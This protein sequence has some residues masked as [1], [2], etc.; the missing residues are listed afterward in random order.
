MERDGSGSFD[1]SIIEYSS[2]LLCPLQLNVEQSGLA[3]TFALE[4]IEP[5]QKKR[6]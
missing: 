2:I 4:Y 3:P 1:V 6:A 5:L